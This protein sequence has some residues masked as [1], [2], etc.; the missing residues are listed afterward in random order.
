MRSWFL[1]CATLAGFALTSGQSVVAHAADP[2]AKGAKKKGDDL[3]QDTSGISKTLQW[4]DKVMGPD[5]KGAEL[6]KIRKAQ[7]INKAAVEKAEKENATRE[8]RESK[9]K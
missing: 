3:S 6:D 4:E 5:D 9:E 7:A 1:V 8:A 2:K